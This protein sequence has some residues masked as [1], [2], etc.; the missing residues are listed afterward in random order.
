MGG[1]VLPP[2]IDLAGFPGVPLYPL[3]V[4]RGDVAVRAQVA[5]LRAPAWQ[6]GGL[7]VLRYTAGPTVVL[8]ASVAL[9][10]QLCSRR[11]AREVA[12]PVA[13]LARLPRALAAQG[14]GERSGRNRGR[15]MARAARV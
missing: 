6:R 2:A 3:P 15:A 5:P 9:E 7:Y 8:L 12:L 14:L 13:R 4:G 1:L 10:R 11:A